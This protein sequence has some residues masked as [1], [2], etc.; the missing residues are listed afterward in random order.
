[1][2]AISNSKL[3]YHWKYIKKKASNKSTK[4]NW[5]R[6]RINTILGPHSPLLTQ[7]PV[8]WSLWNQWPGEHNS[9]FLPQPRGAKPLIRLIPKN[10]L[11]SYRCSDTSIPPS[12]ATVCFYFSSGKGSWEELA[13]ASEG[14]ER[15][16]GRYRQH[17]ASGLLIQSLI[18][19]GLI[20]D[21]Q[22]QTEVYNN[23]S[24]L[25]F[26]THRLFSSLNLCCLSLS[27]FP[28]CVVFFL[29]VEFTRDTFFSLSL[30]AMSA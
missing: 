1:M 21:S 2:C 28:P 13:G 18:L 10:N 6:K 9:P 27:G 20:D 7:S 26:S 11:F 8:R 17:R 24:Y 29:C 14:V 3:V 25:G 15:D 22:T 12:V 5:R 4:V 19:T 16:E 30:K 23:K